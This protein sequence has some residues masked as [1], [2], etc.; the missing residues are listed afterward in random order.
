MYRCLHLFVLTAALG[1][2][3]SPASISIH[4]ETVVFDKAGATAMLQVEILNSAK[5][6]MSTRGIEINWYNDDAD[7]V[8]M[9]E[10]GHLT[11]IASGK[12]EIKAE[13]AGTH[14]FDTVPVEVRI[15][16][17]IRVSKDKLRLNVG[18]TLEDVWAEVITG[19]GAFIE[20]LT[21]TFW[22]EDTSVV[23]VESTANDTHRQT[24][25]RLTGISP[26]TTRILVK[27]EGISATVRVSVFG[28][29]DEVIMV[30]DHISKKKERDARRAAKNKRQKPRKIEF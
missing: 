24:F 9:T 18:Q 27:Y 22:S 7:V 1:A 6:K 14:L 8:R 25:A 11:A 5:E 21:P 28:E 10:D 16:E 3:E 26:G 17:A 30:G 20:G 15:P 23:K 19:R 4:P 13:I 2:C 29:G 12:A